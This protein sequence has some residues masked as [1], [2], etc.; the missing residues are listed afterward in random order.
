MKFSILLSVYAKENPIYLKE[1]LDSIWYNQTLK[2]DEI[3][4]VKDG[5]LPKN[6]DN[7]IFEFSKIAPLKIVSLPTN[8]GLG[9]ALNIGLNHCKNDI[10]ARMDSNDISCPERFFKQINYFIKNPE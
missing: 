6:L 1:A 2:P 9:A 3:V 4:V 5:I 7:T 10:V 8:Q